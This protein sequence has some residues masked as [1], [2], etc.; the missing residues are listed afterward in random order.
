MVVNGGPSYEVPQF[1]IVLRKI[2]YRCNDHLCYRTGL[3]L[4]FDTGNR[5]PSLNYLGLLF[6]ALAHVKDT[7]PPNLKSDPLMLGSTNSAVA[8]TKHSFLWSSFNEI[9]SWSTKIF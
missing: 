5:A 8:S 4:L 1:V 9:P 7:V 2:P 3:L 6:D